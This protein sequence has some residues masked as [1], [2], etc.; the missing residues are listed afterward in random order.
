MPLIPTLS[1]QARGEGAHFPCRETSLFH[2]LGRK[3]R[4]RLRLLG[5]LQA[6]GIDRGIDILDQLG[7]A[8]GVAA[9][10]ALSRVDIRSSSRY[11]E[12][13]LGSNASRVAKLIED[14]NTAVDAARLQATKKPEG[15]AKHPGT[16][17]N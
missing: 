6:R 9:Q 10:I 5:R 12:S 8:R 2:R 7:D 13:D 14:I 3:L 15:A 17:P 1:P 11:F 16:K 4:R